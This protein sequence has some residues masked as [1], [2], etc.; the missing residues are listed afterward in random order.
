MLHICVTNVLRKGLMCLTVTHW[1]SLHC[2]FCF[3]IKFIWVRKKEQWAEQ[4]RML[5]KLWMHM[6]ERGAPAWH[7]H[8]L[9]C[10]LPTSNTPSNDDG[11][12]HQYY[13][14]E[15]KSRMGCANML[16]RSMNWSE[17]REWE[18]RRDKQQPPLLK[19]GVEVLN[20]ASPEGSAWNQLRYK[21]KSITLT[22]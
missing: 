15:A 22:S 11:N 5:F 3:I 14:Q 2:A 6:S 1:Y 20:N 12:D 10:K 19:Y 7:R 21:E 13:M 17:E 18:E 9:P 8:T 4:M 16:L